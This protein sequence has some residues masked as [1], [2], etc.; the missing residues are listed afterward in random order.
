M[1]TSRESLLLPFTELMGL[2]DKF[3]G[4]LLLLV[5]VVIFTY[6]TIWVFVVVS[7]SL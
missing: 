5:S 3:I 2:P 1:P 4:A 6:Y 7:S